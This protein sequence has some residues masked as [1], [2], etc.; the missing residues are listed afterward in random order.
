M[1]TEYGLVFCSVVVFS[2]STD[3]DEQQ[4]QQQQQ[5]WKHHGTLG[6][7]ERRLGLFYVRDDMI[8]GGLADVLVVT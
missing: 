2:F 6:I 5:Q 4:R 8:Y 1:R 7:H 3:I